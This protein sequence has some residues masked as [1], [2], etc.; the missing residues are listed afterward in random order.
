M[1]TS[2]IVDGNAYI[3]KV[4]SGAGIPVQLWWIPSGYLYPVWERYDT[5]ID[6][7]R[8]LPEWGGVRLEDDI[9]VTPD[10][11]EVLSQVPKDLASSFIDL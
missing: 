7:Y 3:L 9:L 2:L 10:G 1:C 11:H 4:R 5:W 8:Y 6:Y